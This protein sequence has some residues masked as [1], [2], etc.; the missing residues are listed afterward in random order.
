MFQG[1][2]KLLLTKIPY[3]KDVIVSSFSCSHC[4]LINN[5]LQSA[6]PIEEKGVRF[7]VDLFFLSGAL[8]HLQSSLKG[9]RGISF[10]IA[11]SRVSTRLEPS[12]HEI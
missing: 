1:I 4:G 2:T 10:S 12:S 9:I 5:D 11:E 8:L 6:S 7:K 3:Y